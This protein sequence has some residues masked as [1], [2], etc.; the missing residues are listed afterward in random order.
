M[1]RVAFKGKIKEALLL[2]KNM[3]HKR[4]RNQNGVCNVGQFSEGP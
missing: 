2:V 3:I 4:R 1:R